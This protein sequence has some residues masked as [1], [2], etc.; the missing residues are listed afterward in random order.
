[1]TVFIITCALFS[2]FCCGLRVGMLA[3]RRRIQN[4]WQHELERESRNYVS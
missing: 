3:E 4:Y 2:A 1:M